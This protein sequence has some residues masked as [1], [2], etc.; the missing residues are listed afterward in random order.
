MVMTSVSMSAQQIRHDATELCQLKSILKQCVS[1][2]FNIGGILNRSENSFL[3]VYKKFSVFVISINYFIVHCEKQAG[4]Q[5][6]NNI[7][8]NKVGVSYAKHNAR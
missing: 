7:S 4:Q 6:K 2:L 8:Q 1:N 3:W 5:M